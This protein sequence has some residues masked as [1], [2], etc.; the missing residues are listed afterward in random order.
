MGKSYNPRQSA[1]TEFGGNVQQNTVQPR[2]SFQDLSAKEK[3][4]LIKTTGQ[5]AD[6]AAT[7]RARHFHGQSGPKPADPPPPRYPR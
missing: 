2:Q 3:A 7:A 1:G 4:R 5:T 6:P